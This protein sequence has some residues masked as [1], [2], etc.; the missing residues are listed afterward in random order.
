MIIPIRCFTCGKVIG[1]LWEKYKKEIE[2]G[3]APKDV[4]DELGVTRYCCRMI[5]LT[6]VDNL[7]EVASFR[8]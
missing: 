4:L 6:H 3:R 8:V 5:F 1:H 2:N 7:K